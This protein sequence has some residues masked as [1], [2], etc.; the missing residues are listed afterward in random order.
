[1]LLA[2][3]SQS[4]EASINAEPSQAIIGVEGRDAEPA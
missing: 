1:M 4:Q 3:I 2:Q